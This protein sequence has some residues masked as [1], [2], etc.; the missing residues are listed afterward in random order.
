[1]ATKWEIMAY[2]LEIVRKRDQYRVQRDAAEEDASNAER[3]R[4]L[5]VAERDALRA[6]RDKAIE[7]RD[8]ALGGFDVLR[9]KLDEAQT[10]LKVLREWNDFERNGLREMRDQVRALVGG[11]ESRPVVDAVRSVV[12]QRDLY[13]SAATEIEA[14]RAAIGSWQSGQSPAEAVRDIVAARD[15]LCFQLAEAR[16]DYERARV[17]VFERDALFKE[18]NEIRTALGSPPIVGQSIADAVRSLRE[19]L[20]EARE[21]I[22]RQRSSSSPAGD[23]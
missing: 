17:V 12:E 10:A 20:E 11:D 16:R 14:V 7:A 8:M 18:R 13:A 23:Q 4:L 3:E 6:E 1:M 2:V 5:A 9:A 15:K 22:R 19:R 21:E